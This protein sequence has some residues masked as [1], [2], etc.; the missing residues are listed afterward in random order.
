MKIYMVTI[1]P[2]SPFGTPLKGDTLFGQFCWQAVLQDDLLD[3]G[4]DHW[5][6]LYTERPF[7]VFSSA[8]PK[9]VDTSGTALFCLPRPSMPMDFPQSMSRKQRAEASKLEKSRKWLLVEENSLPDVRGCSPVTDLEVFERYL[10]TLSGEERRLLQYVPESQQKPII[11]VNRAHNSID[12]RTMTTGKGFDPFT[13]EN[14]HY[15]PGLELVVFAA[16]DEDALDQDRL[17]RGLEAIGCFGFGRDASTG[18]GRFSLGNVGEIDWPLLKKGDGC[19]T[20]APCVPEQ[21]RFREQFALPFTRFGKHG[22]LLVLSR[23]PFKNP[24]VMAD[25]GAVFI[26][27]DDRLPATPY[28]G[29]AISGISLA[30]E[31]TVA[32]GYSLYL[33][34]PRSAS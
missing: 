27:D 4:F 18:L 8:F 26:P 10:A 21:G 9:I 12:R 33:P 19:F 15:L 7:A 14:F 1:K 34:Y 23:N 16:I 3:H 5:I 28:I 2:E 6:R 11:F 22:D 32:Q 24:V 30:E 20:L 25:E 29:T 17:C 13:M 31:K